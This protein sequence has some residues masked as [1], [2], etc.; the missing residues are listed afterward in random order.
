M[1][2]SKNNVFPPPDRCGRY[3]R[4]LERVYAAMDRSYESAADRYGFACNGC[5][6]SCCRTLFYHHTLVEFLYFSA[7]FRSLERGLQTALTARAE[8]FCRAV[9][10]AGKNGSSPRH[11]CPVNQA[12]RCRLYAFRPMICRLHGIPSELHRPDGQTLQ[13]P[14]CAAF[15]ESCG[16]LPQVPFDRTPFYRELAGI[17]QDLRREVAPAGK[18]KMTVA[19]MI[20]AVS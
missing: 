18:I 13:A 20:L 6:E 14:G 10:A 2:P 7:G 4:R 1:P 16:H 5:A 12:D 9:Q 19:E 17:E 3:L 15:A 11:I 8:A